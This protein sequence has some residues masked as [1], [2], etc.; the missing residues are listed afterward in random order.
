MIRIGTRGSPLALI[1]TDIVVDRLHQAGVEEEITV[2]PI[3]TTGDRV[4]DRPL[5]EIGGKGLFAKEI[6]HALLMNEIDCAVHSLKDM[7]TILPEGLQIAAVLPRED[8]RDALVTPK[9]RTIFELPPG[10]TV[11]TCSPRRSAQVL[12]HRPDLK[13]VMLRGNFQTR[14]AKLD[15]G[16]IDATIMAFAGLKRLGLEDRAVYVFSIEEML[17]AVA[18][19]ALAVECR[20]GDSRMSRVLEGINDSLVSACVRSERSLLRELDGSCRTPIGAHAYW[21]SSEEIVLEGLI[22]SPDGKW[23]HRLSEQG[24]HP[25]DLGTTLGKKL[26]VLAGDAFKDWKGSSYKVNP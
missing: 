13:I 8:P 1:Q 24:T 26:K 20:E 3:T 19:G 9:A 6:E 2:V 18:Q 25:E 4:L 14:L 7:E 17:P 12:H 5:A 15:S 16:E 10:S 22:A 11:G 23:V 21:I